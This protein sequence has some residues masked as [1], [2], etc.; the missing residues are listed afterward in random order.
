VAGLSL[1]PVEP[2]DEELLFRIYADTRE[3]ELAAVGWHDGAKE[4]FLRHQF[5]MQSRAYAQYPGRSYQ[6]VLLDGEP[7]GRLYLSREDGVIW[8][9]DIALLGEYRRRG[10]GTA[11]LREVLDEAAA[12]G[13]AVRI[14]VERFNPALRLYERLGFRKVADKGVYFLMERSPGAR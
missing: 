14:H 12:V 10:V 2:G 1:R 11:L 3:D 6:V 5:E 7:V 13:S 8:I 4:A 9:V